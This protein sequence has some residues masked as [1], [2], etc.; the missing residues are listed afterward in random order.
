MLLVLL[1]LRTVDKR[2]FLLLVITACSWSLIGCAI[3]RG[4]ENRKPPEGWTTLEELPVSRGPSTNSAPARRGTRVWRVQDP[5]SGLTFVQIPAGDFVMGA[6]ESE[7]G[8]LRSERP[9]RNVEIMSPFYLAEAEVTRS[10]WLAVMGECSGNGGESGIPASEVSW[11]EVQL[12][13]GRLNRSLSDLDKA[14]GTYRL[15]TEAEWEYACRANTNFNY[16]WGSEIDRS[17]FNSGLEFRL[18][19]AGVKPTKMYAPNPW[20]LYDMHGNVREWCA[21]YYSPTAYSTAGSQSSAVVDEYSLPTLSHSNARVVR[22]G[23]W[24]LAP[25]Y[26]RSA[27][28]QLMR[29][30]AK[31]TD[32]GF[33]VVFSPNERALGYGNDS[34]SSLRAGNYLALLDSLEVKYEIEIDCPESTSDGAVEW[35]LTADGVSE[36][37]KVR[38]ADILS[39]ELRV[40]SPEIF[41]RIRMSRIVLC[42]SLVYNNK[43]VGGLYDRFSATLYL[44]GNEA[45]WYCRWLIHHE[46]F[47]AIEDELVIGG[48]LAA[49][50]KLLD[51]QGVYD[52]SQERKDDPLVGFISEYARSS[53]EEDRAEMFAALI[54]SREMVSNRSKSDSVIDKKQSFIR[55]IIREYGL[56]LNVPGGL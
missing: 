47:H 48:E 38:L 51:N 36:L 22:G 3:D 4:G 42:E 19:T 13:L 24:T 26:C 17:R 21:D 14:I 46:I 41:R 8:A 30:S 34:P 32:L 55:K 7:K 15:P 6:P 50:W 9:L 49:S 23:S 35:H 2:I 28:R 52:N 39:R 16:S 5:V 31:G 20:G 11:Y 29:P 44:N 53:A 37:N 18:G 1:G 56:E 25:K 43:E 33:R 10:Q 40:Y 54:T 45:S 27:A 12:Y